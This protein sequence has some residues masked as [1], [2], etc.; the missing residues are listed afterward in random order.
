MITCGVAMLFSSC[1][2]SV[3]DLGSSKK[4]YDPGAP[5]DSVK[6]NTEVLPDLD[7]NCTACHSATGQFPS[8]EEDVA[9]TNIISN[10]LVNTA[11]PAESIIYVKI[12]SSTAGHGGGLHPATG[13]LLLQWISQ[14]AKNN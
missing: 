13:D 2:K 7:A 9:Y 14:G 12:T 6:F 4:A 5:I 3:I 8:F 1:E 10:G 11:S